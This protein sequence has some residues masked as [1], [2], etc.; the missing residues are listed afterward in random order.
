ML[1]L[2]SNNTSST[3]TRNAMRVPRVVMLGWRIGLVDAGADR[4]RVDHDATAT[5]R[6]DARRARIAR[7]VPFDEFEKDWL[8]RKPPEEILGLYGS[9]PDARPLAPAFR[10]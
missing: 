3:A 4:Q 1:R 7:G 6:H 9:W 2:G 10:P 5:L 8:T